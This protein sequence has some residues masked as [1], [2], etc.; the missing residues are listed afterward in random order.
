M[1]KIKSKKSSKSFNVDI[2]VTN[3]TKKSYFFFDVTKIYP[4]I[5]NLDDLLKL[6]PN[7][8]EITLLNKE[9][10]NMRICLD[11]K[12]C[13]NK[14]AQIL[15][16][17]NEHLQ[18]LTKIDSTKTI[19][20][21]RVQK[22]IED[23]RKKCNKKIK[24]S[25]INRIY[26]QQYKPSISIT[27]LSRIMKNHLNLHFKRVTIKN[28]RLLEN[29]YMMMHFL[30][31]KAILTGIKNDL[32]IIYIDETG[33]FLQ[34]V[35]YRDWVSNDQ[36]IYEGATKGLKTKIKVICSINLKK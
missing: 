21:I 3:Y 33:C 24:L 12:N 15:P 19:Y 14:I 18:K 2:N 9:I 20:A 27:T 23:K 1:L 30:F 6:N 4:C 35:N 11:N 36:F 17:F 22:I 25:I 13:S 32:D 5:R 16:E 8:G 29:N 31:I 34:N 28:P 26:N 10:N 7:E